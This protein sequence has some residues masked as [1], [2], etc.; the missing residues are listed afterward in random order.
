MNHCDKSACSKK[1][2]I[3]LALYIVFKSIHQ[4]TNQEHSNTKRKMD[5]C[6]LEEALEEYTSGGN[7]V[8]F[9]SK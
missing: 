3:S 1:I 7:D 4:S 9:L 5:K 8:C 6:T 2:D